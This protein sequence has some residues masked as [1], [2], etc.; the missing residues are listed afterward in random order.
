MHTRNLLVLLT[1]LLFSVSALAGSTNNVPVT[2]D[3]DNMTA[4]GNMRAARNSKNDV[5]NIG[6]GTRIFDDGAGGTWSWAF[7][8]ATDA[9]GVFAQCFTQNPG[10]V[11]ALNAVA[12]GSFLTF[13]WVEVTPGDYE[14]TKIGASTQ[15]F[16]LEKGKAS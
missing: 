3:L 6:C 13:D 5:E 8:Q 15:S 16:Y 12:D 1:L 9:D 2:I 14:C 7:C 10:L 4:Q 11:A